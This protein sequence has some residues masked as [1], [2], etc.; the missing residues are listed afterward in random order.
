MKYTEDH[1]LPGLL[2]A[3]DFE[4]T[5]DSVSFNFIHQT[6]IIFNFGPTLK[7]WIKLFFLDTKGC[8]QLNGFLSDCFTFQRGFR[9][10]D[11]IMP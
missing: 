3:I 1:N 10:G 7:T 6:L 8:I 11:P 5:F 9:Q 2:M 4:K